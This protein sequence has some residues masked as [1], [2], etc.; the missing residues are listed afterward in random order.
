[1]DL[2]SWL[3][4]QVLTR[5]SAS[6]NRCKQNVT[7]EDGDFI[8]RSFFEALFT[9]ADQNTKDELVV[10]DLETLFHVRAGLEGVLVST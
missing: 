6:E 9:F 8:A 10:E 5:V 4:V 3:L 1:M 7:E 2:A